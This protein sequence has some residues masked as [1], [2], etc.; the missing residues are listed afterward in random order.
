[1]SDTPRTAA[2]TLRYRY[3]EKRGGWEGADHFD[4]VEPESMAEIERENTRFRNGFD[5]LLAA[6]EHAP[7]LPIEILPKA[8]QEKWTDLIKGILMALGPYS[9]SG[10]PESIWEALTKEKAD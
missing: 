7:G 2:A 4:Y 1:M 10:K 8:D 3:H 9:V 6:F 5:N